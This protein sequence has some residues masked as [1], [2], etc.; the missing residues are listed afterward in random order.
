MGQIQGPHLGTII[1]PL[2]AL[3]LKPVGLYLLSSGHEHTIR[4]IGHEVQTP[5]ALVHFT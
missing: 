1:G 3:N 2:V 5:L 4:I